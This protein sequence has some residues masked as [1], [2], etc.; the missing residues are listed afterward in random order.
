MDWQGRVRPKQSLTSAC[1]L[2][3]CC[4][5]PVKMLLTGAGNNCFSYRLFLTV[6]II[7]PLRNLHRK[8]AAYVTLDG[9]EPLT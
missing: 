4:A 6:L 3:D 9:T 1:A 7:C 5:E 8:T 2:V